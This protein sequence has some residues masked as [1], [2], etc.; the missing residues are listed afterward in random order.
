MCARVISDAA[1]MPSGMVI[2]VA[3]RDGCDT[4]RCLREPL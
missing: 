4:E 2:K 1:V 3:L